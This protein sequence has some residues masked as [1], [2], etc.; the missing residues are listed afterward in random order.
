MSNTLP[1]A[2]PK[3]RA[4]T[5]FSGEPPPGTA[6][7]QW[8][9][10]LAEAKA[11]AKASGKAFAD[12]VIPVSTNLAEGA[13][14]PAVWNWMTSVL[15]VGHILAVGILLAGMACQLLILVSSG[16]E[17]PFFLAFGMHNLF[18]F[19]PF[20]TM[21]LWLSSI[22]LSRKLDE[23]PNQNLTIVMNL[24]AATLAGGLV[25]AATILAIGGVVAALIKAGMIP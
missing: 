2:T 15:K 6:P 17:N 20:A 7:E 10:A 16:R 23:K 24:F 21:P 11:K 3:D 12:A 18:S 9:K 5:L 22:P 13:K 19:L 1:G 8:A 4:E 14:P 25:T